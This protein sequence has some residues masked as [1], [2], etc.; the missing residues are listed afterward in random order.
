MASQ[1]TRRFMRIALLVVPLFF[2]VCATIST[3]T[4]FIVEGAKGNLPSLWVFFII[5]VPFYVFVWICLRI[6]KKLQ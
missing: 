6:R 3:T 5:V 4:V 1:N 2:A